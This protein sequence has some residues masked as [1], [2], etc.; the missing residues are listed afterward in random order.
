MVQVIK[1][2]CCNNIFAACHDP[3]CHI[4]TKWL[5][6]VKNYVSKNYQV[7]MLKIEDVKFNKCRCK[8]IYT[9]FPNY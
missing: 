1:Y 4:N 6:D 3:E 8:E 5:K 7:E 2:N 9:L